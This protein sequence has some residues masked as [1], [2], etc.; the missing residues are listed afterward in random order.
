M[1]YK[2]LVTGYVTSLLLLFFGIIGLLFSD[3]LIHSLVTSGIKL[4]PGTDLF[5]QWLNP[6][7]D[8]YMSFYL[9]DLKNGDDFINGEKPKF[10][11]VGP[12]VFREYII[13]ED[14]VDNLNYT[15]TYNERRRYKF[16][17]ELSPFELEY[18][19]T[20]LNM[21]VVTV[22]S[23]V[24]YAS[25]L[26]HDLVNVALTTTGDNTIL[27]KKS[28]QDILFGYED[29]FLK[30]I[31]KFF[32]KLMPS[33]IVGLFT[34]KN[35]TIDGTYT[36][37]TGA[38]Q[39]EKV[40]LV[41]RYNHLSSVTAWPDQ[42]ANM[43]NGTDGTILPPFITQNDKIY[44]FEN[45]L[46]RSLYALYNGTIRV[47]DDIELYKFTPDEYF[48]ANSSVNPDNAGFCTP[49]G[50]CLPAGL[51]NLTNCIGGV[52]IIMTCPHFLYCD[53]KY[54]QEMDG[55]T[56]DVEKH[57]TG[58]YVEPTTGL[59]MKA[60]KRIQFNT[61]LFRDSRINCAKTIAEI[62]FPLFWVDEHFEIDKVNADKYVRQVKTPLTVIKIGKFV[63]FA[64]GMILM[65]V[66][67][68][69]NIFFWKRNKNDENETTV[70][71]TTPLI[72][73]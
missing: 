46:C 40:G 39:Y 72:N 71:E 54:P 27:I 56:P 38:D 73:P 64:T 15:I 24:R 59:L 13:K 30:E 31:K 4:V 6:P 52:P 3:K 51:L 23:Q 36:I 25:S 11:E 2:L 29:N 14:I 18:E 57:Q 33:D 66:C 48:F 17:P 47:T 7:I 37:Y 19:I 22:M 41:E 12:F 45:D 1:G 5:N 67:V 44:I 63:I 65:F 20:S 32:P 35:D 62:L 26:V 58:V 61:Q 9:F 60:N 42:Y 50:N 8:V 69:F 10:Q 28:V 68:A 55:V 43:I 70:T 49:A 53:P 16:V 34:G 21:A